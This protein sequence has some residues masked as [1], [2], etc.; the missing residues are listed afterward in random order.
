MTMRRFKVP[1]LRKHKR[2]CKRRAHN[3]HREME[4]WIDRQ[5]AVKKCLRAWAY[6]IAGLAVLFISN[7]FT[8]LLLEY[9]VVPF[10]LVMPALFAV[11]LIYR[12]LW[13]I[14]FPEFVFN[15]DELKCFNV[16]WY[17]THAWH[18]FDTVTYSKS[19]EIVELRLSTGRILEKI[20]LETLTPEK[21]A[22]FLA[23]MQLRKT[24]DYV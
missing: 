20:H 10:V 21:R 13:L 16:L 3:R 1:P 7:Y 2:Y 5:L 9:A 23:H 24:V 18:S 8:G 19:T 22:A 11:I 17:N 14:K 15:K 4:I 6:A 12:S